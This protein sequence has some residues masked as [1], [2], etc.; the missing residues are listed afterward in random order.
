MSSIK[1]KITRH[2]KRKQK[3]KL[4]MK[5]KTIKSDSEVTQRIERVDVRHEKVLYAYKLL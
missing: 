2:K 3:I 4:P 5:R 1:S